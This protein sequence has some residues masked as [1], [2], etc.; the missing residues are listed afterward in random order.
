MDEAAESQPMMLAIPPLSD[1]LRRLLTLSE[2]D[3]QDIR[4]LELICLKD[5]GAVARIVAYA[6]NAAQMGANGSKNAGKTRSL[7][8]ALSLVGSSTVCDL[9]LGMWG[10]ETLP[11]PENLQA[12][13]NALAKHMLQMLTTARR[14]VQ[15]AGVADQVPNDELML[16]ILVDRLSLALALTAEADKELQE[17]VAA[18]IIEGRHAFHRIPEVASAFHVSRSITRAWNLSGHLDGYLATLDHWQA[19]ERN[20]LPAVSVVLCAEAA[21]EARFNPEMEAL[22]REEMPKVDEVARALVKRGVDPVGLAAK[23]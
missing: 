13:R 7:S 23:H 8:E 2:K 11:V 22:V 5:P 17:N 9:L 6:T 15:F 18:A 21:L 3:R 12:A 14:V 4:V 16:L 19:F 20:L 10:V 1:A